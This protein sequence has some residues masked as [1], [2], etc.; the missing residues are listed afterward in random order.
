[1]KSSGMPRVDGSLWINGLVVGLR[2]WSPSKA[3]SNDR[4]LSRSP[5]LRSKFV[6][7][8]EM[9][10]SGKIL[11]LFIFVSSVE[12]APPGHVQLTISKVINKVICNWFLANLSQYL[13]FLVK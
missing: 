5:L 4:S 12:T 9:T 7:G 10:V 3:L 11:L 2:C 1:M 8:T 13:L 6:C